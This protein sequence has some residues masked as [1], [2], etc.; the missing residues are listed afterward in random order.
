M[1]ELRLIHLTYADFGKPDARV[2]F[3]PALTII[4]GASDTGKSFIAESIEY[5]LGGAKL[6]LVSEAEG[7]SQIL[8]GLQLPDGNTLTLLRAPGSNTIRIHRGDHRGLVTAPADTTVTATHTARSR[9]S[10]SLLLLGQLG[11]TDLRIRKNDAGG[12]REL[13]LSDLVHLS[14]IP[15]TRMLSPLSPVLRSGADSGKAVAAS[16]MRLL[17]TGEGDPDI[18]TGLNAGQR[19]V[20]RGQINLLDQIIVDL[21]ARL[22]TDENV[23]ELRA[24]QARLQ[25]SIDE[26][27]SALRAITDRHLKAVTLRMQMAEELAGLEARLSEIGD[28]VSRFVLLEAQY[29]SDLARLEMVA[30]A[31]SLLGYF[32]VGTCVFCGADPE[33]QH[34]G[35]GE[36]E[37]TQLHIAVQSETTKTKALLNDLIPTIQDLRAQFEDLTVRRTS[38]MQR[39]AQTDTEITE[40]EQLLAPM[41]ERMQ[42]TLQARSAVERNLELHA[43]IEE[44]EERRSRLD[45]KAA[46][47]ATRR[48]EYIPNRIVSAFD[49]TLRRTLDAWTVPSVGFAEYDQ[50]AMDVR[51]GGRLRASRGKGVRSVLHSAFTT[52]LAEYCLANSKPHPGF[53]VLDSPV[54]TYRDPISDPVGED[55]DLTPYVL[56]Q[57]YKNMLNFPGQAIVLEN[58][59]PPVDVASQAHTYCFTGSGPG[60]SGFF[61]TS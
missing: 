27:S 45:G 9:N 23:T 21:H 49:G 30:E 35:H 4:Y 3:D 39:G 46:N 53:V 34:P 47:L 55:V 20:N 18:A 13:N 26:H 60:T 25:A 40:T 31:G 28:L 50:Y 15:E 2:E 58:G 38:L 7:Y 43:R 61:P 36:H 54:V 1:S 11:L 29:R 24:R 10:L 56:D 14:V 12:T 41:R 22:T 42:E 59:D 16:V 51:A 8:L 19:R 5:M 52:A 32:K 37:A 6:E 48:M 17:L 57:F 44:L 33:H